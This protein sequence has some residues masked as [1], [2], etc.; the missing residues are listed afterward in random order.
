MFSV[1]EV[2]PFRPSLGVSAEVLIRY[3]LVHDAH[4]F[5]YPFC[6]KGK[7]APK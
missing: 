6:C 5:A 3:K 7:V 4:V 1:I 2:P